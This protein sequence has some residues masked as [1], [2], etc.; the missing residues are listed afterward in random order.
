MSIN[1]LPFNHFGE[2]LD[3]T[4]DFLSLKQQWEYEQLMWEEL[5]ENSCG[6]NLDNIEENI[7]NGLDISEQSPIFDTPLK[8][9]IPKEQPTK[10]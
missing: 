3:S 6:K 8:E 9:N 1:D 10:L 5:R 7:G 2:S 4:P